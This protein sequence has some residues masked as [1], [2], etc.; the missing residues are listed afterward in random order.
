[1]KVF[2]TSAFGETRTI[3]TEDGVPQE[4]IIH[5]DLVLN[6]G[7]EVQAKIGAFHP[8]LKGYFATTDRG[9]VFIPT[10]QHLTDGMLVSA[11]ITKE[12]RQDKVATA[13]LR[14]EQN[15]PLK[16]DSEIPPEL[17]DEIIADAI[18][19][20]VPF[21][22]GGMLHIE[23]THVCWTID[24]DSGHN[25]DSLCNL[26]QAAVPEINRQVRLKNMGGLIFVD[27]AG[28]KRLAAI[29]HI[30]EQFRDFWK[31]D[32]NTRVLGWTKAGLLEIE[33]KRMR[34]DLWTTC[35]ETNPINIYYRVLRAVDKCRLSHPVLMVSLPVFNL[36]KN[37]GMRI[38][39]KPACDTPISYFKIEEEK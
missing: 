16:I 18:L 31:N 12:A 24:V 38:K 26:N 15:P 10:N 2:S 6:F 5:R 20:D 22:G 32:P 27:F 30:A 34:A 23:K 7:D 14:A 17:A 11:T 36:L 4:I 35:A 21:E 28:T 8:I 19:P 37:H 3:I 9:D 39:V 25:F 1:M 33:R 13:H 29:K